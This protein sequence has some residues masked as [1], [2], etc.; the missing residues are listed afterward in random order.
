MTAVRHPAVAV[1]PLTTLVAARSLA[2]PALH[3]ERRREAECAHAE[4]DHLVRVA[5]VAGGV[6]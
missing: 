1:V 6:A 4:L 5:L 2:D 3:P